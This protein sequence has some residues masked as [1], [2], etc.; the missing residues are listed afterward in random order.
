MEKFLQDLSKIQLDLTKPAMKRLIELAVVTR[1]SEL[2]DRKSPSGEP[3]VLKSWK[4]I[5]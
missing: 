3:I 4:M 2:K 5:L 1:T